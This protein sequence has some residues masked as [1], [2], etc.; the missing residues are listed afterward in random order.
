MKEK[1]HTHSIPKSIT[2]LKP[3]SLVIKSPILNSVLC[4]RALSWAKFMKENV[5]VNVDFLKSTVWWNEP[6][7]GSLAPEASPEEA[8]AGFCNNFLM[9]KYIKKGDLLSKR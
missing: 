4:V 1:V 7:R 9:G 8:T 6:S 3:W 5:T 2:R